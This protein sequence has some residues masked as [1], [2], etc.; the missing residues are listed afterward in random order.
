MANPG[1]GYNCDNATAAMRHLPSLGKGS[2]LPGRDPTL[3]LCKGEGEITAEITA[4]KRNYF[5]SPAV[6]LHS[7]RNFLRSFPCNPLVSAS[8]EHSSEA[9]L[10]TIGALVSALAAGVAGVWAKA[11]LIKRMDAKA[12][13]IAREEMVVM[14][15]LGLKRGARS[16]FNAEP[17]M[18]ESGSAAFFKGRIFWRSGL[19]APLSPAF[20]A[21]GCALRQCPHGDQE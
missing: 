2:G 11:E 4:L 8:L 16:R 3:S 6:F 20:A 13:A 9:A 14:E 12:V 17:S 1:S 19:I 21:L 18:N 10:C 15:H 7:E 5:L